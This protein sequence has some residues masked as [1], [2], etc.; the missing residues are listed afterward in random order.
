[1]V[2]LGW[3][4]SAAGHDVRVAAAPSMAELI[5]TS[6]LTAV[7]L[8][9]EVDLP[10]MA[11]RAFG[12]RAPRV[13]PSMRAWRNTPDSVIESVFR[14]FMTTSEAMADELTEFARH[15]RPDVVVH[16]PVAFIAPVLGELLGVPSI[17]HL[18]GTD[19]WHG[20][21]EVERTGM[22]PL[23]DRFG[24][25][26]V[27]EPDVLTIDPCPPSLQTPNDGGKRA[28]IA[29]VP[30][31]GAAT[32]PAWLTELPRKPRV[33]VTA[34]TSMPRI[35]GNMDLARLALDAVCGLDVE[36]VLAIGARHR[37]KLG[38]TPEGVRVV[39]S[40]PLRLLLP[41]CSAIVHQG[42]AGTTLTA[43]ATGTPQ[44]I[45][46]SLGDQF[47]NASAVAG[48]GAGA[49]VDTPDLAVPAVRERLSALLAE[50]DHQRKADLLRAENLRQPPPASVVPVVESL[51]T[52]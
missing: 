30:Y 4:L 46:P 34:G 29:Y 38:E 20:Y 25:A 21:R 1:M 16:E 22:K 49:Y 51:V 41:T 27:A 18:W 37:E 44:L 14:R 26:P 31:N 45:L 42:G 36:I 11:R 8:G 9:D 19:A 32:Y 39:E 3:A 33:C 13:P 17:R 23:W 50:P 7:S 6:G 15:W 47:L 48:Y 28:Q 2:P 52:G 5:R 35:T 43:A 12:D 40:L 24:L 10:G